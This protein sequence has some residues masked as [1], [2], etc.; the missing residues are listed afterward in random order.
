MNMLTKIATHLDIRTVP[1]IAQKR[2]CSWDMRC[3]KKSEKVT[4][5]CSPTFIGIATVFRDRTCNNISKPKIWSAG[6]TVLSHIL[7]R[8]AL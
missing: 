8:L 4:A 6:C 2:F 1:L 3:V 5:H 7:T